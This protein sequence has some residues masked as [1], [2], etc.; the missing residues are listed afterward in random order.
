MSGAPMWEYNTLTGERTIRAIHYSAGSGFF[1][2]ATAITPFV[3]D[4][5]QDKMD[6]WG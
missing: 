1:N 5:I 6:D 2:K 3:F 4:F